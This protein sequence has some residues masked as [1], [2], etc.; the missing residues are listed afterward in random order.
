MFLLLVIASVSMF[1]QEQN[2]TTPKLKTYYLAL[3]KAGPHRDQDSTTAAN[4]QED[5]LANI[6][7]LGAEGTLDI[8]GPCL[9]DGDLKGIFI[10]N[11]GTLEQADSLARTD[12]AVRA[13]R[14]IVELHP[15]MSLPGA[16]LR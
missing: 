9:D 1:S 10:Y 11:V 13:G 14:L 12:P 7:K 5:H 6:R 8:A 15:W 16:K 2:G 3:L 4:I